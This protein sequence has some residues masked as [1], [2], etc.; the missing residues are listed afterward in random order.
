[1]SEAKCAAE[2]IEILKINFRGSRRILCMQ[3]A[4]PRVDEAAREAKTQISPQNR[5]CQIHCGDEV[6]NTYSVCYVLKV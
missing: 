6:Q 3:L 5:Y 1:M 2:M 4:S